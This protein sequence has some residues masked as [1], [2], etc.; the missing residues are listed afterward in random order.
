MTS[1]V[2]GIDTTQIKETDPRTGRERTFYL[3]KINPQTG[4][5]ERIRLGQAARRQGT[6]IIG[7]TGTG[8]SNLLE[9]LILQDIKQGKGVAVFDPHSDL[10]ISILARLDEDDLEKVVLL[11]PLD[12]THVFGLNLYACPD[13]ENDSL[14]QGTYEQVEHI[15]DVLWHEEG[16]EQFGPQVREGLLYRSYALI[17]NSGTEHAGC[18]ML[19]IPLLFQEGTPRAKMVQYIQDPVIR[20]YWENK[21]EPF[22][23][24]EKARRAD[25]VVN[26]LNE[27]IA[28]PIFRRIVG[29]ST[30]TID[31]YDVMESGKILLVKLPGRFERMAQILGAMVIA[32]LLG[33]SYAREKQHK[34]PQFN[35]YAD[36]YQRFATRD[37]AKLLTEASRK[38]NTPVTIAHQA[39]DFIDLKNKAASLQVA[40]LIVL[41]IIRKDAD[42]F[43]GN[44][45]CTP[46]RTKKVLKRRTKPV[47]HYWD[48]QKWIEDGEAL[49]QEALAQHKAEYEAQRN[50]LTK[51]LTEADKQER[52]ASARWG[53]A[54]EAKMIL[55][56]ASTGDTQD[57][58]ARAKTGS[59]YAEYRY[60]PFNPAWYY[61][62]D[63]WS[64]II[65]A[66]SYEAQPD[67]K[68]PEH[69]KIKGWTD[70]KVEKTIVGLVEVKSR[71]IN[72]YFEYEYGQV[73]DGT[74]ENKVK[75]KRVDYTYEER[76]ERYALTETTLTGIQTDLQQGMAKASYEA[77]RVLNDVYD[78]LNEIVK[79][80]LRQGVW[81]KPELRPFKPP[82]LFST[83]RT[84][85]NIPLYRGGIWGVI[86]GGGKEFQESL[87]KWPLLAKHPQPAIGQ[88]RTVKGW[89][90]HGEWLL[91][92]CPRAVDWLEK[93]WQTLKEL[94]EQRKDEVH[95]CQER[96]SSIKQQINDLEAA[97]QKTR[98][99]EAQYQITVHHKDY[100]GEQPDVDRQERIS[101]SKSQG[102]SQTFDYRG[103][104]DGHSTSGSTSTSYSTQDVQWYDLVEELD[105]TPEQRRDEIA[106]ELAMLPDYVARIRIKDE[107]DEF[108]EYTIR[109]LEPER[110]LPEYSLKDRIARIKASMIE[111]QII[112]PKHEIDEEIRVRQ[113]ALRHPQL[114]PPEDEPPV[115]RRK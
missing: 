7:A 114:E 18:G 24:Y 43:A 113:Q 104:P 78:E 47:Y 48:E 61:Y 38:Y 115:T 41:R 51:R 96:V 56:L 29:Q 75:T 40:N 21:F 82:S 63:N 15:F 26:K 92:K 46:I 4:K 57:L 88:K 109:T 74:S 12:E 6:Y 13:P 108:V 107:N 33:A 11:D 83:T 100:L 17:Y 14:V 89:L 25:M 70:E 87:V 101:H 98:P 23:R 69:L 90:H 35:I 10:I 3:P 9:N 52:D 8:K 27:F 84:Y 36:E 50:E 71:T 99:K 32:Q 66:R 79:P 86:Y 93:W 73:I 80:L 85:P 94:Y 1:S 76:E 110:G 77:K 72:D 65:M 16:E 95:V 60:M 39:R 58:P 91:W 59:P 30:S 37:F 103:R 28:N 45:D 64:G 5:E 55:A 106:G 42:E 34:R 19:E 111:Q 102:G 81:F 49:Y 62:R 20:S 53:G 22:D 2:L 97:Y 44:L 112:R 68:Y 67:R 54:D 31:F 105:Q